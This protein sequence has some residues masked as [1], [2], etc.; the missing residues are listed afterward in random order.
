MS[1][2]KLFHTWFEFIL[3]YLGRKKGIEEKFF[4][5]KKWIDFRYHIFEC[6]KKLLV[7]MKKS[8]THTTGL[9]ILQLA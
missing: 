6:F 5:A 9:F 1:E 7:H 2:A 3:S 8:D 4:E